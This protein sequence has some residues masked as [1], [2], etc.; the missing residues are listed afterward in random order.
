MEASMAVM[1]KDLAWSGGNVRKEPNMEIT[2]F[3]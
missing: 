2:I 1:I 3:F